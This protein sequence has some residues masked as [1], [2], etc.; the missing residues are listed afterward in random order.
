V[1]K[2]LEDV[3]KKMQYNTAIAAVMEH[4]N[5]VTA[6]REP[7]KL[8]EAELA[9]FARA[10]VNIPRLLYPF[11]PHIAEELWLDLGNE[12]LL[13]ESG[14]PK[15]NP[16]KLVRDTI[17]YVVQINGKVRG[18]MDIVPDTPQDKIKELALEIENV[19]KTLE[20]KTIHK[21]IIVPNKMVSI[22]MS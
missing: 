6:I 21:V 14:M 20:G 3:G 4:L 11:A 18:K 15:F 8:N 22:A 10:C 5:N 19:K 17:S 16:D 13:H 7:D 1:Q 9:I 12:T 2:W